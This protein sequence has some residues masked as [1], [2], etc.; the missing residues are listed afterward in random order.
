MIIYLETAKH[1]RVNGYCDWQSVYQSVESRN[2]ESKLTLCLLIRP[3]MQNL[4][5]ADEMNANTRS[6]WCR[7]HVQIATRRTI[8]VVTTDIAFQGDCAVTV[9]YNVATAATNI[10]AGQVLS[11][12]ILLYYFLAYPADIAICPHG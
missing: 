10:T 7:F 3:S 4:R 9:T 8:S 1:R 5:T 12:L 11:L 6:Y 2:H